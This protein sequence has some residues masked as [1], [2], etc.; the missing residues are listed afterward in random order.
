MAVHCGLGHK[1]FMEGRRLYKC[2]LELQESVP[3][4]P[5]SFGITD[6]RIQTSLLLFQFLTTFPFNFSLTLLKESP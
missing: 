5:A 4:S 6:L 2:H 1:K 3:T